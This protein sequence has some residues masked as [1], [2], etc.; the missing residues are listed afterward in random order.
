MKHEA[1]KTH[2]TLEPDQIEEGDLEEN[3]DVVLNEWKENILNSE[4]KEI[5]IQMNTRFADGTVSTDILSIDKDVGEDKLISIEAVGISQALAERP[6]AVDLYNRLCN[7]HN[8]DAYDVYGIAT[9][10]EFEE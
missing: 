7:A 6:S 5:S 10:T 1:A 3:V 8:F 9:S 2:V 4:A